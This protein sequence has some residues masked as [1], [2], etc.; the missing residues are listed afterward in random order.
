MARV[1]L[2]ALF[3]GSCGLAPPVVVPNTQLGKN[4]TQTIGT[5]TVREQTLVRPQA[6]EINQSADPNQVRVERVETIVQNEGLSIGW[7]I[8]LVVAVLVDS[9]LRW[10]EQIVQ[11]FRR[12]KNG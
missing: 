1:I 7:I 10:P 8:A 12:K 3:L 4:N 9:P 11:I 6:R 5:T 2:L